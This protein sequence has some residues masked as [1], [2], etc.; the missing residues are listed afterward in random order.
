MTKEREYDNGHE[1]ITKERTYDNSKNKHDKEQIDLAEHGTYIWCHKRT[2]RYYITSSIWIILPLHSMD[3][4][5]DDLHVGSITE[6]P[7]RQK[8]KEIIIPQYNEPEEDNE[9]NAILPL[10]FL[11]AMVDK[12]PDDWFIRTYPYYKYLDKNQRDKDGKVC[13]PFHLLTANP[14][15]VKNWRE[16]A[17]RV[18]CW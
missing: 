12:L 2:I 15:N 18:F 16:L 14:E 7:K 11:P 4:L 1:R 3:K 13:A 10:D 17:S 9:G 6:K 8:G 5:L